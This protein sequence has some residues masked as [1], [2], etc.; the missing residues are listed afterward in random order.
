MKKD[1]N[2]L[3]YMSMYLNQIL[4]L[5]KDYQYCDVIG[6]EVLKECLG[7]YTSE[8][9]KNLKEEG[10]VNNNF[11]FSQGQDHVAVRPH[12]QDRAQEASS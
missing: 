11:F 8:E 6:S 12:W 2:P 9:I 4:L 3:H 1:F 5:N 7:N 10:K